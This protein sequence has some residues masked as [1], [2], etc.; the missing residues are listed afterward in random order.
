ML[1]PPS[2]YV[3]LTD[4]VMNRFWQRLQWKESSSYLV[5][6]THLSTCCTLLIQ[7]YSSGLNRI[8]KVAFTV[9]FPAFQSAAQLMDPCGISWGNFWWHWKDSSGVNLHPFNVSQ[10][11]LI[12]PVSPYPPWTWP[13]GLGTL[14]GVS[15]NLSSRRNLL[16]SFLHSRWSA[17]IWSQLPHAVKCRNC[18][19]RVRLLAFKSFL[20]SLMT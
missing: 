12:L 8:P 11:V 20:H 17:I 16:V 14:S 5:W 3:D 1:A 15:F 18:V 10:E 2:K 6:A 19:Y 9:F 13:G 7:P 4:K